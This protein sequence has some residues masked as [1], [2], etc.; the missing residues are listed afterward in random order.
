MHRPKLRIR[1]QPTG[2]A[3]LRRLVPSGTRL[4]DAG[5]TVVTTVRSAADLL[6][7]LPGRRKPRFSRRTK[8]LVA[9]GLTA[10]GLVGYVLSR[11]QNT[12]PSWD[13]DRHSSDSPTDKPRATDAAASSMTTARDDD[14]LL[15]EATRSDATR[16]GEE[17]ADAASAEGDAQS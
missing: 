8:G 1:R 6:P 2:L 16:A 9:F 7:D 11:R 5:S 10:A 14:G 17:D 3:R 15:R 13:D 4:Q 12:S